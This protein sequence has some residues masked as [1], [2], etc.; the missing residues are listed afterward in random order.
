MPSFLKFLALAI[1]VLGVGVFM[2]IRDHDEV[3]RMAFSGRVSFIEWESHNHNMPLIE[4]SRKNGTKIKFSSSRI[5]LDSNQLKVGDLITKV[6]GSTTCDINEK[7]VPCI[8]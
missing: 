5:I 3:E 6:S 8:K 2:S 7:S 4:I 1:P